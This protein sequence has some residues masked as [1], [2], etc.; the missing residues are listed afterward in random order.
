MKA[1]LKGENME[2]FSSRAPTK[3]GFLVGGAKGDWGGEQRGPTAALDE[4]SELLRPA[5]D[6]EIVRL[7][8]DVR[9]DR[10]AGRHH[11]LEGLRAIG[12]SSQ[13]VRRGPRRLKPGTLRSL[14]DAVDE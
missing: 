4:L 10:G 5:A 11:E 7:C 3:D 6:S 8:G 13:L 2:G 12:T 9:D 1:F 14:D